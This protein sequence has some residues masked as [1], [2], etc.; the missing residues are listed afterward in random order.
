MKTGAGKAEIRCMLWVA[1]CFT[2]TSGVYLSW[3]NRLVLIA[4]AREADWLSMV[5]GYLFQAGGTG[6]AALWLRRKPDGN[7]RRCFQLITAL[8][9]LTVIPT[10]ITDT[11][12][13]VTAFGWLMNALCGMLAGGYLYGI[14]TGAE[15]NRRSIVFGGGYAAG[16]VA[17]GAL[18]L[19]GGGVIF[20]GLPALITFVAMTAG[21]MWMTWRLDPL[22]AAGPEQKAGTDRKQVLFAFGVVVLISMVKNLGFGFPAADIQAGLIPEIARIPYAAG[23]AAAGL[24][25]AKSRRNG[26]ICTVAAM[27]IPFLMLGLTDEPISGTIFWGLDYVFFAFF[28]VFR[29]VLFLDLAGRTKRWELAPLGLL[30]GRLGDAAGTAVYLG[31]GGAK[32]I[33]IG[34]AGILFVPA[35]FLLFR[36]YENMYDFEAAQARLEKEKF[37]EFCEQHDF[38]AREQDIF[39][40]MTGEKTY[41]EIAGALFITENTVKYHVRNIFQKTGCNS[42]SELKRKYQSGEARTEAAGEEKKPRFRVV[43]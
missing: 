2:L 19:I 4:G 1:L 24:I 37:R 35:V 8:F 42:R 32:A 7:H 17:V 30:A 20:R 27:I 12:A 31:L 40:L 34:L 14:G 28:S 5:A 26:M 36:L 6:L 22:T 39:R 16:T 11:P 29:V 13:G 18:A 33:L 41:A 38:S 9:I 25:S 43:S 21:L 15:E 3:L 10:L 23:L